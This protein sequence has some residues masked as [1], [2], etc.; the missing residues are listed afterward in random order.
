MDYIVYY[1]KQAKSNQSGSGL[2][3]QGRSQIEPFNF[4]FLDDKT[5]TTTDNIVNKRKRKS[6][7]RKKPNQIK[8]VKNKRVKNK[9]VK[10]SNKK[11]KKS[12]PKKKSFDIFM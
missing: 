2:P 6:G 9:V 3:I 4:D 8:K 11:K 12:N 7:E 5:K 1:C 10:K